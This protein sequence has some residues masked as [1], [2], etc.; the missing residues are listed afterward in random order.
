MGSLLGSFSLTEAGKSSDMQPSS[1]KRRGLNNCWVFE[2]STPGEIDVGAT[3]EKRL[4][5]S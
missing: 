2:S 3:F 1:V 4:E 5:D